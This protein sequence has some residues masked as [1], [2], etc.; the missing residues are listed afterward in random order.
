MSVPLV[1]YSKAE[2][3]VL[4]K[5]MLQGSALASVGFVPTMGSLHAGHLAL[6]RQAKLDNDFVVVSIFVNPLQ[7]DD[8]S[9]LQNYPKTLE[10]DLRLLAGEGVD[11]VFVPKI[12]DMYPGG[13]P[14]VQIGA[15]EIGEIFEGSVRKGHFGGVLTV[16]TK[17]FSIVAPARAYFGQKDAQ[18][19][20][21]V[22]S[23]V[24]DLD[25]RV[26]VVAVPI[27]REV[28]GL[29]LSSRNRFLN[30]TDHSRALVLSQVL[31]SLVNSDTVSLKFP[32]V[33]GYVQWN[34]NG[35]VD[36]FVNCWNKAQNVLKQ[37][38]GVKVDYFV[39]ADAK[40]FKKINIET[41][42]QHVTSGNKIFIL[43]ATQIGQ[44]RLLD[45][46]LVG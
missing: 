45:N 29:A 39:L 28:S 9:D 19:L 21:L 37:A 20:F 35:F 30:T 33:Q 7:F 13:V 27:V 14:R 42:Q 11:L 10:L 22:Q 2:F 25:F 36:D 26:K 3:F 43:L 46:V 44:I 41:A 8:S 5:Q 38:V 23:L 40:N 12:E 17:L 18:Q 4:K 16:V 1:A 34:I 6:V 15:G 32:G 31:R 24:F